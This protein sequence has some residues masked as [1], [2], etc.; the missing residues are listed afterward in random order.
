MEVKELVMVI[1]AIAGVLISLRKL[2]V[3]WAIISVGMLAGI[4]LWVL[5]IETIETSVYFGFIALAFLMALFSKGLAP[6]NRL[7]IAIIAAFVFAGEVALFMQ[8]PY[9]IY[10]RYAMILPVGIYIAALLGKPKISMGIG[11]ITIMAV[12]AAYMFTDTLF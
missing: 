12:D 3:V 8:W 1:A 9:E 10:L 4:V 5:G 2:Q 7:V 11:C 6:A